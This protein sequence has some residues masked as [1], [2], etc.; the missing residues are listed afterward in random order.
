VVTYVIMAVAVALLAGFTGMMPM[1]VGRFPTSGSAG[2][3]DADADTDPDAASE[4]HSDHKYGPRR[5]PSELLD[6]LADVQRVTRRQG[7][8]GATHGSN[9]SRPPTALPRANS[10]M[11]PAS[12]HVADE[13]TT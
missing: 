12:D 4:E 3:P 13:P 2:E 10:D 7:S 6:A 5:L 9:E 8:P 11:R 1:P